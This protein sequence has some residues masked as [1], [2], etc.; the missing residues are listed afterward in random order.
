MQTKSKYFGSIAQYYRGQVNDK[1]GAHGDALVR[2]TLAE[3][4]VKEANLAHV[5]STLPADKFSQRSETKGNAHDCV[6]I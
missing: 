3:S 2:Y 6:W 5:S 4:L 1:A